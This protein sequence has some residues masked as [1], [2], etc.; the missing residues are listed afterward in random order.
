MIPIRDTIPAQRTAWVVRLLI[1]ANLAVFLIEWRQG[2]ALEAFLYRFGV[3]PA[4]WMSGAPSAGLSWAGRLIPLVSSQFLH[5]GLMHLAANMLYLWIFGDNVED[6]VGHGRFAVLYLGSGIL[7]VAAQGWATPHATVPM[8]G[9]SGAIAGV[10]GAYF[11]SFPF[12]RVVTLLPL[13]LVW[14]TVELPA[15]VFLGLWFLLQWLQGAMTMG[16]VADVG[17]VAWWAHVGGFAGGLVFA[18]VFRPRRQY[19]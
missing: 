12:A 13:G 2:P 19:G 17:G 16:H 10:L 18:M 8:I 14:Q 1:L 7:A 5:G 9:A 3:V 15:F 6:R 4:S 11:L